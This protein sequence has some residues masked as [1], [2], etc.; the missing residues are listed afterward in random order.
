MKYYIHT[1][2]NYA[3]FSGRARRS[4]FWYFILF[5]FIV[6]FLLGVVN[7]LLDMLSGDQNAANMSVAS[8]FGFIFLLYFMFVLIPYLAVLVRRLHDVNRSGWYILFWL[9]P[10]IGPFIILILLITDSMPGENR[11]GPNP[12]SLGIL[13]EIDQIGEQ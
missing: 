11:Y 8:P 10:L 12:Q 6:I 4:E 2:K 1:L 13:N 9:V 3:N 7:E 5:N